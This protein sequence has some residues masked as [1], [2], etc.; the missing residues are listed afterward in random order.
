MGDSAGG[1]LALTLTR[2]LSYLS[3]LSHA[4]NL[5]LSNLARSVPDLPGAVCLASPWGDMTVS[6]RLPNPAFSSQTTNHGQDF[7]SYLADLSVPAS[8]RHYTPAARRSCW[9][10]PALASADEW[11]YLARGRVSVYIM[12]GTRELLA[13]EVQSIGAAMKDAGVDVSVREV[14]Y[15]PVHLCPLV[16]AGPPDDRTW[17]GCISDRRSSGRDRMPGRCGATISGRSCAARRR[18]A[19][20]ARR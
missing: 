18:E 6:S 12:Y 8:M 19:R 4:S 3:G 5:N 15:L 9:F 10:S 11:A 1:H 7:V 17:T 2:Y 14:N 13:D 20:G 16:P